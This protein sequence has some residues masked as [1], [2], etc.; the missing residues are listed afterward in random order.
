MVAPEVCAI[1]GVAALKARS[2]DKVGKNLIRLFIVDN[3]II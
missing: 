2:I 1:T 3:F